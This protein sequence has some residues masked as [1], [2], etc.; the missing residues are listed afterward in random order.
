MGERILVRGNNKS[1]GFVLRMFLKWRNN[2][3]IGGFGV[4]WVKGIGVLVGENRE[5]LSIVNYFYK[6]CYKRD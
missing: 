4:N 3:V 5:I 1:K 6:F 2:K